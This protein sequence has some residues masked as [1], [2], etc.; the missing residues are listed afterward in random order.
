MSTWEKE[1]EKILSKSAN[2]RFNDL[3]KALI[4]LGYTPSQTRKGSSHF[5]FRKKGC[6]PIV[7][8]K[9]SPMNSAYIKLVS[10]VVKDNLEKEEHLK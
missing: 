9:Q 5:V 10:N 8:P 2:L 7:L 6:N 4:K 1:V 3:S